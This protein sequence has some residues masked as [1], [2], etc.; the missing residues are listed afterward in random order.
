MAGPKRQHSEASVGAESKQSSRPRKRRPTV[1]D[2]VAGRVSQYGFFNRQSAKS[3][4]VAKKPLR[5]D[6][7]LFKARNAPTRYDE[8]DYYFAHKDL[9]PGQELPSGDLLSAT[10]GYISGLYATTAQ[11]RKQHAWTSMDETAL[12]AL[13]IL[14]EETAREVLGDTGDLAFLEGA[15][16]DGVPEATHEASKESRRPWPETKELHTDTN[17]SSSSNSL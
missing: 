8:T 6:E 16:D 3:K 2:A 14:M 4:P 1:Y 11:N 7:I 10:H 15:D 17:D 5:P 12:I 9:S 13:G